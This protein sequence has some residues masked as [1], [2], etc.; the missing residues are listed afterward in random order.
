MK[1][2]YALA[3]KFERAFLLKLVAR[4]HEKSAAQPFQPAGLDVPISQ[5]GIDAN[6]REV[7]RVQGPASW[8]A[9]LE[10]SDYVGALR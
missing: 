8:K 2:G 1:S 7:A 4:E 9:G 5:F 6:G 3:Q 10:V